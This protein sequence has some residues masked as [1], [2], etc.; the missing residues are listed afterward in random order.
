MRLIRLIAERHRRPTRADDGF[1]LI[2]M[3]LS[4]AILGII[5]AALSGV[6]LQYLQTTKDTSARLNESTDQQFISAYWQNDVSS[7]GRQTLNA[8]SALTPGQS[9][10]VG[11]AG[12]AGCGTSVG[13]VAVAF[14][15]NEFNVNASNPANAWDTTPH[16]VAYVTI[17][18]SGRLVLKR[19]RCRNGAADQPQTVAHNL[20]ATPAVACDTA[21]GAA[22][23]PNRV[24]M[25]FTVKDAKNANSQGYTT[26]LSA[27]R[28]QG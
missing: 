24:S 16:E 20:T 10:F 28:R 11:S 3:V 4:V 1:T 9:V 6:M 15:W 8:S 25:T 2:E 14:A 21:C 7:L 22:T 27:D 26:T 17:P 5:S 18:S 13:T 19:V 23:P 12:P